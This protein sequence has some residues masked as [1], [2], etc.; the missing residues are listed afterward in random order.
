MVF[1]L[2]GK[3]LAALPERAVESLARG[4]ASVLSATPRGRMVRRNLQMALKI[5]N[6]EALEAMTK[7]ACAR[8]VELGLLGLAGEAF[9][10]KR[11]KQKIFVS[12]NTRALVEELLA[13]ERGIMLLVPHTTLMEALTV[14]PI[15]FDIRRR[16]SVLYR[17]FGSP[18]VERAV[19]GRRQAHGVRLLSREKGMRKLIHELRAGQ[20]AGLLFDQNSGDNGGIISFMGRAAAASD[21]PDV[22]YKHS[23]AVPVILA[24][25]RTGFWKGELILEKLP[26]DGTPITLLANRWLESYLRE[27]KTDW[28]WLH[29]RWKT[30]NRPQR[31]LGLNHQKILE[32]PKERK[33]KIFVRMPN[34]LGDVV[35]AL[36]SLRALRDSR[37]DAEITLFARSGYL[38]LLNKLAVADRCLGIPVKPLESFKFFAQF[39]KNRPDVTLAY[40]NSLRGDI[41]MWLTGAKVRG[42]LWRQGY[43][44][45]LINAGAEASRAEL[46]S[47]HQTQVWQKWLVAMGLKVPVSYAPLQKNNSRGPIGFVPGSANTPAKRYPA[48]QW[49]QLAQKLDEDV[50]LFGAPGEK[51]IGEEIA[52]DLP[53]V[54]NLIGQ[55]D[56]AGLAEELCKCR[57]VIG[58]DTG[59]MHLANAWGVPTLVVYGPTSPT[60]TRPIFEAPYHQ[61]KAKEGAPIGSVGVE[62]ILEMARKIG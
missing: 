43:W 6:E 23:D 9:D 52:K 2:L 13:Q 48:A 50:V 4:C 38:P 21:L 55:T 59:A 56:M 45:P 28:L 10:D 47:T 53:K 14:M 12:E 51:L 8:T 49:R 19:L 30:L 54:K 16:V 57:L 46:K 5:E 34:W 26:E 60:V 44:R 36:P 33:T 39:K 29:N 32:V 24:I 22:I 1:S 3:L 20:V 17:A 11:W 40:T 31:V 35:M 62:E 42:G 18:A 25:K 7:E 37:P 61:I 58:N 15:F 41:E 27:N